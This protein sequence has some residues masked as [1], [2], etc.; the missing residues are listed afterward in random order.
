MEPLLL[1][2]DL[3]RS[4]RCGSGVCIAAVGLCGL[5][6][7]IRKIAGRHR[8]FDPSFID[9]PRRSAPNATSAQNL[10]PRIVW[11]GSSGLL[12]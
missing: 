1:R 3:S 12:R 10:A 2:N 8:R 6:E 7:A 5:C 4:T 11:P 9:I